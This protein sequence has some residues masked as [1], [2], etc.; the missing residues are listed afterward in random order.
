MVFS[1]SEEEHFKH[2]ASV[3]Q[4][5]R[6]NNLFAKA[7][8]RVSHA[9][10]VEYLGYVVSSDGLKMDS[11]K[12]QQILH[13]PQSKNIKALRS[14]LGFANFYHCFIKN[15]PIKITSLTSL[16]K[17]DSPSIF[18]EEALSQLQILKEAFITTPILSHFN[19]SLPTNVE[20]DASDYAL[21]ALLSQVNESGK[22]PIA[23]DSFMLLPA[24]LNYDIHDKELLGIAWKAGHFTRCLFTLAQHVP[25]SGM[26][27]IS[28]N[29]QNLHQIIKQHGLQESRF[30]SIKIEISSDLYDQIQNKVWQDKDYKETLK[31]LVRGESVTDYSLEPQAKLLLFKDR[32]VIPRNEEIQPNILQKCHNSP[33]A[34]HPGQEKA[35]KL[36]KREFYLSG[37]NQF[38]K[39]YVSVTGA[40]G[41]KYK[42]GLALS[43]QG[44][45]LEDSKE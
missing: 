19:P 26:D 33:L 23:F 27:F 38:I 24:D 41:Q 28:N 32:V 37:M 9:S 6:E 34:G 20:T 39:D 21:G 7:S 1:S 43:N 25:E 22:H 44:T 14:F 4:R 29:P 42:S 3:L 13:W 16:L 5:L 31:K 17:K 45:H 36:I 2:V 10:S 35:L 8:K 11:S 12:V 30:F 18:N 40:L 15:Y